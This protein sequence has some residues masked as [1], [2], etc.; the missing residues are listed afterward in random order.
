MKD[1]NVLKPTP[2]NTVFSKVFH[3]P[4]TRAIKHL[5]YWSVLYLTGTKVR[6]CSNTESLVVTLAGMNVS[7]KDEHVELARLLSIL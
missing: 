6:S 7:G 2:E 5:L 3:I 4:T 1:L